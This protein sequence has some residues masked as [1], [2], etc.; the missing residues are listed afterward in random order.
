MTR[1]ATIFIFIFIFVSSLT[2]LL[3]QNKFYTKADSLYKAK[4]YKSGATAYKVAGDS[5]KQTYIKK[6]AYYNAACCFAL[7][8][9]TSN[10]LL[11]LKKAVNDYGYRS[12]GIMNDADLVSLHNSASW[13]NIAESINA[14]KKSLSDPSHAKL[15]TTD[16]HHFWQAYDAAQKDTAHIKEIFQ[17]LYFDKATPGLEDYIATKIGTIEAF[18]AS[19]KAKRKFYAAIRNNTLSIDTMKNEIMQGFYKFKQLYADAVFP[20]IY[21]LIGR[22]NS[23]GTVSD[24]G[25]LIGVD[26][27]AKSDDIPTG[28]L[29]EWSRLGFREVKGMPVII[30]HE[31]IHS[32]QNKL[33][34]DTTVLSYA[35]AEGMADFFAELITG[36]NPSQRQYDFAKDKKKKIWQDFEKDMYFNRY[37]NWI[38]NG[39]QERP[40]HPS[41]LGYYVGYEICKSYYAET[42]DKKQAII[43][44]FNIR[45]YNAFLAKSRYPEKMAALPN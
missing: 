15:I 22:G 10:A 17:A 32:Q 20:D 45:D 24:N 18:V 5:S 26:Q 23:A 12:E 40:D 37:S 44:I 11:F 16:I 38:A 39:D 2:G 33:K 41:D 42:P 36:I 19:Q 29:S 43:D 27:I 34:P 28:E 21:F 1:K 35:I 31:L 30:A 3:A 9:D 6:V 25:L 13:K 8:G 4:N 14:Y 7:T